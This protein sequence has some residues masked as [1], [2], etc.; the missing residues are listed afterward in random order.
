MRVTRNE[1]GTFTAVAEDC[2][3][4]V[5]DAYANHLIIQMTWAPEAVRT[6]PNDEAC[7][8]ACWR[9]L[10]AKAREVAGE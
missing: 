6:W 5:Y 10:M 1:D 9:A 4:I 2:D 7:A 3:K 8:A